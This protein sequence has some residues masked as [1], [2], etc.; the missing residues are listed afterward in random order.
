[1]EIKFKKYDECISYLFGL[2]RS[3]IKYDLRNIRSLL[4]LLNQPQKNFKAIHIAGTNGKGSVSSIINSILIEKGFNTGLYTSPHI[5]DFRERIL[6]NGNLISKEFILNFVNNLLRK[7]RII[8][9]SF[10]EITTALA[11]EYFSFKKVDYAVIETGLGGRLDSTNVLNPILSVITSIDIDHTEFLGRTI[12]N[13]T[14]EKAGIIKKGVPVV[15]GKIPQSSKRIIK[16]ISIEKKA[17]IIFSENEYETIINKKTERGFFLNISVSQENGRH[18]NKSKDL[19]FPVIGDYQINN[20]KTSLCAIDEIKNK[21]GI[22]FSEE[23]IRAGLNNIKTNSCF[24][25]RFEKISDDPKIVIDVSH[26]Y[27]GIKNIESN[28]KY[29]KFKELIII[30]AMMKD[31]QYRKCI[32]ELSN[33]RAAKIILTSPD[34]KRSA[35][36]K[37][38]MA[39]VKEN[40]SRFETKEN[41][42]IAFDYAKETSSQKDLILVTGS[43]FLV[44]DF[45][46]VKR[47]MSN[48]K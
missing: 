34:Y 28:L 29:F 46:K 42:K 8:K 48:D 6:F 13:I 36:P 3:G 38:L 27:Q 14:E 47:Q 24:Y 1:M 2:E 20:I 11:F 4:K 39:A 19:F 25:G 16:R 31:K 22:E 44:S 21:E 7:I 45:L 15:C 18:V 33:L 10:F 23:E 17:K 9:P 35:E 37:V 30:F 26:N 43:F 32:K 40:K 41:V 5:L 12:K